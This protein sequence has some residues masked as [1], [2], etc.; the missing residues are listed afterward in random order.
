MQ[1]HR[2]QVAVTGASGFLGSH[3]ARALVERGASVRGVVRSPEKGR[4]LEP[5]GVS[6]ERADLAETEQ[7]ERAFRGMHVVV[8][9]AA[10]GGHGSSLEDF[11]RANVGG[12]ENVLRAAQAAG[13]RRVIQISTVAV[14]RTQLFRAMGEDAPP[15]DV[16][17]RRFNWSDLTTD[18]RY[19]RTK[20]LAEQRAWELADELD[21]QLTA[22]RPGPIYGSR[23]P[24]LTA[25]WLQQ[26]ERP[27][28]VVPT[29]GVPLVHAG[30]VAG[31]VV[32]AI[33]NDASSGRAYN[34]AGPPTSPHR[35]FRE[36]EHLR[37]RGPRLL[38]V[39]LPLS[40]RY[41]T[42]RAEVD[43][44]FRSRPLR[45]GLLEVLEARQ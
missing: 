6:F 34:L 38:V 16:K 14:Y 42:R 45:A 29:V 19:A 13:V 17:Q 5:L 20:T 36:L 23:D 24:K 22:L 15:Y 9:N 2:T 1:V 33:N 40:V 43:L 41:D 32:G 18:W 35:V 28:N 7:L 21:L 3:I 25:R 11:A 30:D 8:A 4:F 44:G 27:V 10:L 12:T 31:A 37:G 26:A 39:P